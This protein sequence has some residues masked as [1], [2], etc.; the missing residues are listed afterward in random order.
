MANA[1]DLQLLKDWDMCHNFFG[2]MIIEK[3]SF[4]SSWWD[5]KNFFYPK[6]LLGLRIHN[7][8]PSN[9]LEVEDTIFRQ[10]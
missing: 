5:P 7:F 1:D 10:N 2:W 9:G 8:N 3:I 4:F 6:Y